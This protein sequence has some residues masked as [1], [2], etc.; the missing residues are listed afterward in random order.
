MAEQD[1]KAGTATEPKRQEQSWLTN[2]L[3]LFLFLAAL[4]ALYLA[5][6]ILHTPALTDALRILLILIGGLLPALIYRSFIQIRL[7]T[8]ST[9]YRQSLRRLGYP[10]S[11]KQYQ[12]NNDLTTFFKKIGNSLIFTGPTNTN[13]MDIQILLLNNHLL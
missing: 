4:A 13:V 12:E 2:L 11:A 9:E 7:P 1:V 10:E 5:L 6:P 3:P 8:L